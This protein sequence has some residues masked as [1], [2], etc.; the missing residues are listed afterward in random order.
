[1]KPLRISIDDL[2]PREPGV[3]EEILQ[4]KLK[5]LG[6][7][8]GARCDRTC[9]CRIGLVCRDHVCVEDW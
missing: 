1:M 2:A 4:E 9:D 8:K 6:A 3:S 7:D 5:S